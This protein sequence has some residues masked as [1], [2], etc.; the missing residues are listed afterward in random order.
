MQGHNLVVIIIHV[1]DVII[2]GNHKV[3]IKQVK[4]E[5]KKWFKTIDLGPL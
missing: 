1:D 4:N 3:H 5:L 2:T